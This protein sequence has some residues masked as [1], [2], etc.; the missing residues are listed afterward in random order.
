MIRFPV[1]SPF[2]FYR[3]GLRTDGINF[4]NPDNIEWQYRD[5][6]GVYAVPF[7]QPVQLIW[8]DFTSGL[9]FQVYVDDTAYDY[10]LESE[11]GILIDLSTEEL[12][13][14]G[15]NMYKRVFYD[16]ATDTMIEDGRYR[17][18]IS[19]GEEVWFSEWMDVKG[20]GKQNVDT[21]VF[22]QTD[23]VFDHCVPFEYG[24]FENDFGAIFADD[25]KFKM[26]IP[27]R[28]YKPLTKME[29]NVYKDDPGVMTTLRSVPT[30]AYEF[31]TMPVPAWFAEKLQLAFGCSDLTLN[32]MEINAEA[33]PENEIV[34][35]S[36]LFTVRGEV[37]LT[38]YNE[39]YFNED[40][41]KEVAGV[42]LLTAW[43][44]TDFDTFTDSGK[45][46][47]SAIHITGADAI[48]RSNNFWLETDEDQRIIYALTYNLVNSGRAMPEA[49]IYTDDYEGEGY[50]G[51]DDV[52]LNSG[53]DVILFSFQFSDDP[54]EYARVLLSAPANSNFSIIPSLKKVI[55]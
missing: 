20:W 35:T 40:M 36:D 42:E 11:A 29:K 39:D 28:M 26:L 41:N 4:S 15:D 45:N 24:H 32:K 7:C 43:T 18:K 19:S 12:L 34:S 13:A 27:I 3:A 17:V 5:Q 53:N 25:Y 49:Q 30:R 8:H 1:L 33:I 16:L 2:K 50:L 55:L 44:D 23:L 31:E 22:T 37:A 46:I 10:E 38:K 21:S 52:K 51:S 48:A 54:I 14:H 9:D 6:S 47:S